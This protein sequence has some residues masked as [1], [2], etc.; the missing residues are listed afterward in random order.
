MKCGG[1]EPHREVGVGRELARLADRHVGVLGDPRVGGDLLGHDVQ[2]RRVAGPHGL[3]GDAEEDSG[4]GNPGALGDILE[5]L[6]LRED[7]RVAGWRGVLLHTA[8]PK[9]KVP[10]LKEAVFLFAAGCLEAR[11]YSVACL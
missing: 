6:G 5:L 3:R 8:P 2:D 10:P 4:V 7:C 1:L 11:A 9:Y